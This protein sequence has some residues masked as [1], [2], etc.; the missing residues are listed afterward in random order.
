M[1]GN[2]FGEIDDDR[3]AALRRSAGRAGIQD[4]H[5]RRGDVDLH[6]RGGKEIESDQSVVAFSVQSGRIAAFEVLG[7]DDDVRERVSADLELIDPSHRGLHGAADSAG[8]FAGVQHGDFG[9]VREPVVERDAVGPGVEDEVSGRSVDGGVDD[10]T[11]V[12]DADREGLRVGKIPR[13]GRGGRVKRTVGQGNVRLDLRPVVDRLAVVDRIRRDDLL[14]GQ[15]VVVT[16]DVNRGFVGAAG[17]DNRLQIR[18]GIAVD[19]EIDRIAA[20]HLHAHYT[21]RATGDRRVRAH[22]RGEFRRSLGKDRALGG[23][24]LREIPEDRRREAVIVA[25]PKELARITAALRN[26]GAVRI[27]VRRPVDKPGRTAGNL[28]RVLALLIGDRARKAQRVDRS[29]TEFP[30]DVG[31]VLCQ[32]ALGV[33]IVRAGR[34]A[35]DTKSRQRP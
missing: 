10:Q 18:A 31:T 35:E 26:V 33:C 6:E 34:V 8:E 3:K 32:Q 13:G 15:S 29:V 17:I 24:I 7:I 9:P 1:A 22:R 21:R 20:R 27:R 16:V 25:Q 19:V 5:L 30:A 23:A 11:V 2:S 14:T 12:G 28:D 4:R